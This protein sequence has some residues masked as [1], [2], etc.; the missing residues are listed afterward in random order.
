VIELFADEKW[1]PLEAANDRLTAFS[2]A[3]LDVPPLAESVY[4][5]EFGIIR[6]AATQLREGGGLLFSGIN[7]DHLAALQQPQ[8]QQQHGAAS[9][10]RSSV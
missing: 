2:A 6:H 9:S 8:H 1:A 4:G 10:R 7:P 5:V 3:L